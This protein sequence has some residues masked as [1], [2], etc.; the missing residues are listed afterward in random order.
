MVQEHTDRLS[1]YICFMVPGAEGVYV[2]HSPTKGIVRGVPSPLGNYNGDVQ[3]HI[4]P[5][6][7]PQEENMEYL[8]NK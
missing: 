3:F 4:K 8:F 6:Y 5:W 1:L 2:R 7:F